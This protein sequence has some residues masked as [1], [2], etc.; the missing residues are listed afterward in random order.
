MQKTKTMN[1]RDAEVYTET[2]R[3]LWVRPVP[4]NHPNK[5]TD[6]GVKTCKHLAPG[7]LCRKKND[8]CPLMNLLFINQ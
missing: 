5:K 7:G 1:R 2:S 8:R 3:E 6:T 4:G